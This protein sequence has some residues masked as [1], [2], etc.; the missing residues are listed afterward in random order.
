MLACSMAQ[1]YLCANKYGMAWGTNKKQSRN[2]HL[3]SRYLLHIQTCHKRVHGR[4]FACLGVAPTGLGRLALDAVTI[5]NIA[6]SLDTR[7]CKQLMGHGKVFH[8]NVK[9][10]PL[11]RSQKD[12]NLEI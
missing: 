5:Q 10:P 11:D 1:Y 8:K 4:G 7:L 9:I 12:R 3:A 6:G 2:I